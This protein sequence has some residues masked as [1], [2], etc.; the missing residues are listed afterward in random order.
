M[1]G[2]KNFVKTSEIVDACFAQTGFRVSKRTI[3][4]DIEA[5]KHDDF[6]GF[7]AP[8][9]Y[10]NNLKAY[11]Y[12]TEYRI[13]IAELRFTAEELGAIKYIFDLCKSRVPCEYRSLLQHTISKMES[14]TNILK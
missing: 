9:A 4:L 10:N 12:E 11:Y 8:I 7:H 5:M 3:Q 1:L 2:K 6:L 14:M 13:M